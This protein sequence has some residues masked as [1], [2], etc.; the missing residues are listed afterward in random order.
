VAIPLTRDGS[1]DMLQGLRSDLLG[2][3][4]WPT[5]IIFNF[6]FLFLMRFIFFEMRFISF[7]PAYVFGITIVV[8]CTSLI[9]WRLRA[10]RPRIAAYVYMGGLVFVI[11]ALIWVVY[12]PLSIAFLPMVILL[13]MALLGGNGMIFIT[14]LSTAVV[15]LSARMHHNW[16][17]TLSGS[18]LI[19]WFTAAISW[20]S[21][22]GLMTSVEW[23]WNSYKQAEQKTEE[24]RQ[25][26][27]E[28][29][30]LNKA[31][32]DAYRRIE[33]YSRQ[34]ARARETAEEARR[35][36]LMF[37]A[38]V[39]H[40]LRTPLNIIIGFS[41]VLVLSPETYGVNSIPRQ[42]MGDLNR[43]YRSAQH[44]KSLIDDVLDLSQ[45]DSDHMSL[46][47]E[48]VSPGEV[49]AEAVDMIAGLASHKGLALIT[50][51]SGGLPS[52]F[53]DRLRV[54][55]VLLNLLNNAIRLTDA[56]QIT[57]SA[58]LQADNVLVT[59]SDTGPGI[60]PAAF[61]KI[62]QEFQQ[63][64]SSLYHRQGGTG[65][66]LALSRRFIELHGGRMWVESELGKGSRFY[67]TLPLYKTT[68]LSS[69]LTPAAAEKSIS[70]DL[71]K[72][73]LV[74]TEDP[75]TVRLLKR[76]FQ[77]YQVIGVAEQHLTDAIEAYFPQAILINQA[78]PSMPKPRKEINL[79]I[80][81]CS[82][83]DPLQMIRGFGAN[84]YLLKPISRE[85]FLHCLRSFGA[86][87]Q[88]ILII[89]DDIQFI[90]LLSRYIK[91]AGGNFSVM[92]ASTGEEGIAQ[93]HE[94]IPDL[95]IL[96]LKM[97]GMNG[98][99]VLKTIHA[100]ERLQKIPVVIASALDL[101]VEEFQFYTR[102]NILVEGAGFLT[103]TELVN[104]V[105]AILDSLPLPRPVLSNP[106]KPQA[107][108][109]ARPV[110]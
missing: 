36:K 50:D 78:A 67:F 109:P 49:I 53:M 89:D 21:Y 55:Q 26:R 43:I 73:L 54:R 60:A 74:T 88:K 86:D 81:S 66:G 44:L 30:K 46:I 14:I 97:D 48:K 24:A 4:P 57:L 17:I 85:R 1:R 61:D 92:T 11:L 45:I 110:S 75:L 102:E 95:V 5:V 10:R 71:K 2:W 77:G 103:L 84:D 18:L 29:F 12:S 7:Q 68:R 52:V 6:I 20:L 15:L 39:S 37:V 104:C 79:P 82:L 105:R 91:G 100:N 31:L 25:H 35:A 65:L 22:R 90:E 83:P 41:E 40:E 58:R 63:L 99:E 32:N 19:I 87:I 13:S 51:V 96:D 106:L 27:A 76:L 93:L 33:K 8:I 62:F 94:V 42:F 28:L 3:L 72:T 59:V 70:L 69:L 38:N 9:S 107:N 16:D 23:A 101:P 108:P 34:L 80:I 64:E 47:T 98:M 56:G